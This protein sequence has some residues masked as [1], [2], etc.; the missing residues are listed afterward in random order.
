ML[1]TSEAMIFDSAKALKKHYKEVKLRLAQRS[2]PF[3]VYHRP[4]PIK[5][6]V[7]LPMVKKPISVFEQV[8]TLV[9][10]DG[11]HSVQDIIAA[12]SSVMQTP[13]VEIRG[14]SRIK[15]TC[16]ARQLVAAISLEL[17][18]KGPSWVGRF[19]KKDHSTVLHG[20]DVVA[21]NPEYFMPLRE[22]VLAILDNK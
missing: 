1:E 7:A 18:G 10:D 2:R 6:L 20:R 13:I 14:F 12:V 16:R 3:A 9:G 8:L 11:G 22:Q 17:T 4:K 15:R 5:P 19:L 21:A